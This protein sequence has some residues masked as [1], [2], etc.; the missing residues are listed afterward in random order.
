MNLIP[1]SYLDLNS[2]I[3][4]INGPSLFILMNFGPY[5]FIPITD[6]QIKHAY[7]DDLLDLYNSCKKEDHE[8]IP[9][10]ISKHYYSFLSFVFK[11]G[12]YNG[13]YYC[14]KFPMVKI[15][16]KIANDLDDLFESNDLKHFL[17]NDDEV[18]SFEEK[19]Y[20]SSE[21]NTKEQKGVLPS[22]IDLRDWYISNFPN[23]LLIDRNSD[24]H[25][26]ISSFLKNH[27]IAFKELPRGRYYSSD[28]E[29]IT[30]QII[31]EYGVYF[32]HSQF[33]PSDFYG[34]GIYNEDQ[35]AKLLK[36]GLIS[37]FSNLLPESIYDKLD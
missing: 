14:G 18:S 25:E 1:P 26:I 23:G 20:N 17:I 36:K 27:N 6:G 30:N 15:P 31:K 19:Y 9:F 8:A 22:K 35:I 24:Y 13:I 37:D 21:E 5:K 7:Y 16:I 28:F 12:T 10:A 29:T 2:S 34:I 33:I 4:L 3:D 11:N 32:F